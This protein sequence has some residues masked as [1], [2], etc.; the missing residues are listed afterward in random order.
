MLGF[1]SRYTNGLRRLAFRC[2]GLGSYRLA[3]DNLDELCGI[4]LSHTTIGEIAD[5][6]AGTLAE[7]YENNPAL[8]DAL[9]EEFQKAKGE[10]EYYADG[11]CIRTRN[12]AGAI[13]YREVRVGA[14]AK[15]ERSASALPEEW[16]TR[17]LHK[18]TAVSALAAIESA[19]EFQERCQVERRR[20]GVGGITSALGDGAPWI[21]NL[22]RAVFGKA[23]ECLDIYHGA[24]HISDCGKELYGA[25]K[26]LRTGWS[27]CV[28]CCCRRVLREWSVSYRRCRDWTR[29]S[30]SRWGRC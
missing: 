12:D 10:T 6:T 18:P 11:T 8:R 30:R 26:N 3:A 25:V 19:K 28:W 22:V 13:E 20:I 23:D 17:D 29:N 2:A 7:R 4:Q 24:E 9:R 16:G 1:T 15:R 27:V 14:F 5:E 21:W